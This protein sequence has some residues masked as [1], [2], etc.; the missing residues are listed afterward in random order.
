MVRLLSLK[1]FL[2][3]LFINVLSHFFVINRPPIGT[4]VWRQCNTLA[5]AQNFADEGM[6]LFAPSIDR[7]GH[8]DGV[9]GSH[10]PLFEWLLAWLFKWFGIHDATSRIFSLLVF[11]FGM[12]GLFKLF[13]FWQHPVFESLSAGILLLFVPLNYYDSVNAMPD[14]LALSLGIWSLYCFVKYSKTQTVA[15]ILLAIFLSILTGLIKFQFLIIPAA[16]IVFQRFD[17]KNSPWILFSLIATP[18]CVYLWYQ[19]A[20]ELTEKSNLR[21]FGLWIKPI[22]LQEKLHTVFNNLIIDLP[23]MIVGWPLLLAIVFLIISQRKK[24]KFNSKVYMLIIWAIGFI[25]FYFI[26]IER[27]K[28]HSY[29]FQSITP[30]AVILFLLLLK[31]HTKSKIILISVLILQTTWALARI[32]PSRW[33]ADKYQIP[34]EFSDK[35]MRNE[36]SSIVPKGALSIIG[37][38]IS[39]CV[40]FYFTKTKGYSY[41]FFDEI[42]HKTNGS[43]GFEA[44]KKHGAKYLIINETLVS[45]EQIAQLENIQLYRKVGNFSV[46]L[47]M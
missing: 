19:H 43:M 32:I 41:E 27:F 31:S 8:T 47:I 4:H 7:R 16:S 38:D 40:Y 28:H 3:F 33:T 45:K 17:K 5:M 29:Y 1:A 12:F 46:W 20:I 2:L 14:I 23:E 11:S 6:N 18:L 34:V 15:F 44:M 39:G 25:V 37:P 26:A 10:F 35:E 9:T 42:V 30:I 21:E 24:L 36:L 13:Q 22:S